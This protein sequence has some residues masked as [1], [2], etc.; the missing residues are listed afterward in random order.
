MQVV[1]YWFLVVIDDY[2][3]FLV[4]VKQ[5]DYDPTTVEVASV[6]GRLRR[7]SRQILSDHGKQF[8]DGWVRWCRRN[9]VEA[10]YAHPSYT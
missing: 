10:L 3:W 9:G 6:L 7:G 8:M 5:C 2:S 4:V 1:K